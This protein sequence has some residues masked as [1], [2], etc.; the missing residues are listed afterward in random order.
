MKRLEIANLCY[1]T[2]V[3]KR[4]LPN[5]RMQG[6]RLSLSILGSKP[7]AGGQQDAVQKRVEGHTG[8]LE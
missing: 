7:H 1:V 2:Q 3:V 8:L 6:T 5:L 4:R